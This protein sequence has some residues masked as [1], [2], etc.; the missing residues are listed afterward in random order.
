MNFA[1][2]ET[3]SAT[4]DIIAHVLPRSRHRIGRST[5]VR[6]NYRLAGS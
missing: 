1:A 6:T 4:E 2:R 3:A 5:P